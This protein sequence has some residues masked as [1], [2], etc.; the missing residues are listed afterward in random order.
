MAKGG[1]GD[2]KLIAEGKKTGRDLTGFVAPHL[3][4]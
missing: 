4:R 1:R 2:K 3:C